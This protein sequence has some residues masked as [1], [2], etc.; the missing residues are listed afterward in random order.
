M[1]YDVVKPFNTVNRRLASGASIGDDEHIEPFTFEERVASGFLN[2]HVDGEEF[3]QVAPPTNKL[4]GSAAL[5][6]AATDGK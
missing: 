4:K 1:Q 3:A 5:D 2:V 6:T